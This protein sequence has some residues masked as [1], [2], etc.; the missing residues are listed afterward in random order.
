MGLGVAIPVVIAYNALSRV[1][2]DKMSQSEEICTLI[3]AIRLN[4]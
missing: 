4:K 2:Q 3:R 1:V